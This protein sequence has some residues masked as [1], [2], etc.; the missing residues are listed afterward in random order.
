MK[1]IS[2]VITRRH[3]HFVERFI[4]TLNEALHKRIDNEKDKHNIQCT[5]YICEI[6]LTYNNELKH[7]S[8][9]FTPADAAKRENSMDAI[10]NLE[11]KAKK[12]QICKFKY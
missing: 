5:D 7:Y 8:H 11:M 1:S 10:M 6:M 3:A 4:R 9:G 12:K 2:H